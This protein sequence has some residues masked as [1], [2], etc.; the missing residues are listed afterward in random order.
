LATE[1]STTTPEPAP[2][3]NWEGAPDQLRSAH[4]AA[5]TEAREAQAQRDNLA[6]EVAML[7]AG[8][9]SE[10]PAFSY[11]N[12]GYQG[13]LTPED[14]KAEWAKITGNQP[15]TSQPAGETPTPT[16][17]QPPSIEDQMRQLQEERQ[18]LYSGATAPGQEPTPDPMDAALATFHDARK[19]GDNQQAAM[20]KA[21]Q[22]IFDAAAAGDGRVAFSSTAEQMSA[23]KKRHGE[24]V[25]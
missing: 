16:P 15:T 12:A 21:F 18:K 10:H 8:V 2:V 9:D 6:R 17:G 4:D 14:I 1:D 19:T 11:F 24:D 5:K 7:R 23:W 13:E 25:W 20:R 3:I 22:V